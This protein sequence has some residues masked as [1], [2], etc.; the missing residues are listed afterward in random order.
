MF[1]VTLRSSSPHF[2]WGQMIKLKMNNSSSVVLTTGDGGGGGDVVNQVELGTI[3]NVKSSGQFAFTCAKDDLLEMSALFCAIFGADLSEKATRRSH[4]SKFTPRTVSQALAHV[5]GFEVTVTWLDFLS[6]V[7]MALYYQFNEVFF[8]DLYA[9][10]KC[11][12]NDDLS[13]SI[14]FAVVCQIHLNDPRLAKFMIVT[15]LLWKEL[16]KNGAKSI[17]DAIID[18]YAKRDEHLPDYMLMISAS[19]TEYI[20]YEQHWDG[21][22]LALIDVPDCRHVRLSKRKRLDLTGYLSSSVGLNQI[23]AIKWRRLMFQIGTRVTPNASEWPFKVIKKEGRVKDDSIKMPNGLTGTIVAIDQVKRLAV[24]TWDRTLRQIEKVAQG[25]GQPHPSGA[26]LT[27]VYAIGL[28][29]LWMNIFD[30][31]NTSGFPTIK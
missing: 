19:N 10:Y 16:I 7:H 17:H 1:Q 9:A 8:G 5:Y 25:P 21:R 12:I 24:V 30:F 4:V 15:D 27:F 14:D 31:E 2:T 3:I 23:V 22:L 20:D 13:K 26:P 6:L 11:F 29:A 18:T 28:K